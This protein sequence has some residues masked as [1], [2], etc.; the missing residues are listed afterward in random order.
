MISIKSPCL[1]VAHRHGEDLSGS[2]AVRAKWNE[3]LMTDAIAPTYAQLLLELSSTMRPEVL[4]R[5]GR[6]LTPHS[7][8]IHSIFLTCHCCLQ[9]I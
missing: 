4:Y 5:W 9:L 3:A 6:V 8:L 2:G 1:I 7:W